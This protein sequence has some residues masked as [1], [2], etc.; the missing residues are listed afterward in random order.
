MKPW[1]FVVLVVMMC[2]TSM[3]ALA[4]MPETHID[5]DQIAMGLTANTPNG[6]LVAKYP[7]DF[8]ACNTLADQSLF[9]YYDDGFFKIGQTYKDTHSLGMCLYLIE[10]AKNQYPND[11]SQMACALG[12]CA[13]LVQDTVAHND[14]VE[15]SIKATG[16]PNPMVHPFAEEGLNDIV[17]TPQLR[18]DVKNSL[19]QTAAKHKELFRTALASVD[20]KIPFDT[21]FDTFTSTVIGTGDCGGYQQYSFT[22]SSLRAIPTSIHFILISLLVFAVAMI[23]LLKGIWQN[24]IFSKVFF[25]LNIFLGVFIILAYILFLTNNIWWFFTTFSRPISAIMPIGNPATYIQKGVDNTVSL[26]RQGPT[27]VTSVADPSGEANLIAAGKSGELMRWVVS[28]ILLGGLGF[29]GYRAFKGG[30]RR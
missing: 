10:I 30:K 6:Q 28:I 18:C 17:A 29:L 7:M 24:N 13:H 21:M 22:F 25:I 11:E 2:I 23:W 5:I 14:F 27:F 4:F 1:L 9:R 12:A 15:V 3:G 26:L 16:L 20:S 19:K 8:Y